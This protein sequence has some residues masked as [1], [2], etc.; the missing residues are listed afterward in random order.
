MLR[1][2]YTNVGASGGRS[3]KNEVVELVKQL[4][5]FPKIE[6]D[7]QEESSARG[8][9]VFIL[10]IIICVLVTFEFQYYTT[11]EINYSY[12]VDFDHQRLVVWL[13]IPMALCI[14]HYF[15]FFKVK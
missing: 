15:I 4:D 3:E 12:Q 11:R 1:Q 5:A 10:F 7:Y 8:L 2:K 13:Q 14:S 6:N 9:L